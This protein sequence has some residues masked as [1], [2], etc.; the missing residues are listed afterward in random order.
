MNAGFSVI[1][2]WTVLS[3]FPFPQEHALLQLVLWHKPL[4]FAAI[5]YS[6][7]GMCFTTPYV[8]FSVLASTFY[9]FL[10]RLERRTGLPVLPAY[11][12]PAGRDAL[13]VIAG[14]VHQAKHT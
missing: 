11:P 13:F 5:K 7:L 4:I 10:A 8:L 1:A 6:Y 9:I 3:R 2:G 14:E 12:D